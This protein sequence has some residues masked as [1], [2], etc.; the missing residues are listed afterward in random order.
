MLWF[1]FF[2]II[3]TN[4]MWTFFKVSWL[5]WKDNHLLTVGRYTYTYDRR[6]RA[7]HRPDD[8]E[9]WMLRIDSV[10]EKDNGRYECQISTSPP[11]SHIV[12]LEIAGSL[13]D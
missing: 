1:I 2:Y 11:R 6:F 12:H 10:T 13:F 9:D 8:S 5:R 3:S 7:M 4:I